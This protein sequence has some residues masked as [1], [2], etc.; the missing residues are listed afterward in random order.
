[1]QSF[2]CF[3][4]PLLSESA[5]VR[6]CGSDRSYLLHCFAAQRV[7]VLETA[8]VQIPITKLTLDTGG[9]SPDVVHDSSLDAAATSSILSAFDVGSSFGLPRKA[10]EPAV[11][12]LWLAEV[13]PV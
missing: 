1:M 10:N 12:K 7:F 2:L 6:C 11:A 13:L 3:N 8:P 5:F 4:C 9:H